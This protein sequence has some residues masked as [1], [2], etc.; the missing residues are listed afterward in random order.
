M[1]QVPPLLRHC[2]TR[3]CRPQVELREQ[4]LVWARAPG[5]AE[6]SAALL[7]NDMLA[8]CISASSLSLDFSADSG[9][10]ATAIL[11]PLGHM[12]VNHCWSHLWTA[13]GDMAGAGLVSSREGYPWELCGC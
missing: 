3:I 9:R 2:R 6:H 12:A 7:H 10:R 13:K 11:Y 1:V 8:F 4:V 5:R